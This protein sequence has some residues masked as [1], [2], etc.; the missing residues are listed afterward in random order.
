M[1]GG[2]KILNIGLCLLLLMFCFPLSLF[3]SDIFDTVKYGT[4]EQVHQTLKS[5]LVATTKDDNRNTSLMNASRHNTNPSISSSTI[6]P[7]EMNISYVSSTLKE[8]SSGINLDMDYTL[9]NFTSSIETSLT[10]HP[11][12]CGL[13]KNGLETKIYG[14]LKYEN[15]GCGL[16]L[17]TNFWNGTGDL[18]E[19]E[20]QTGKVTVYIKDFFISYEND[21]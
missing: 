16:E 6:T 14:G 13:N 9:H 8:F 20:Q 10:Y 11:N 1:D 5:G 3:S 12:F 18:S 15:R 7:I 4:V 21:G 2:W 17:G 19:F